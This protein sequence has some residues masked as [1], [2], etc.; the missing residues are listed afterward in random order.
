MPQSP[1]PGALGIRSSGFGVGRVRRSVCIRSQSS[2]GD[3]VTVPFKTSPPAKIVSTG[4]QPYLVFNQ[5]WLEGLRSK[6]LDLENVDEVFSYI[7]SN[8]PDE[9]VV[10]PTEN[11]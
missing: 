1:I 5:R 10:Y 4:D 11:Y 6:A 3:T 8:L 9:V 2:S 7:F